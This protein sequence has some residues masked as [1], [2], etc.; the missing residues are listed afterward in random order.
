MG[1]IFI[2]INNYLAKRKGLVF[3]LLIVFVALVVYSVIRLKKNE[4]FTALF[5]KD[6][7]FEKFDLIIKK[8]SFADKIV[9]YFSLKDTANK[10]KTELLIAK[11]DPFVDSV[12]KNFGSQIKDIKYTV[13]DENITKL[14]SFFYNNLPIFLTKA[15]YKL[16]AERIADSNVASTLQ[17]D[18]NLLISPA[19]I[20][21]KQFILKDPFGMIPLAIGKLNQFQLGENFTIADNR[22]F[23]KDKNDLFVFL[24]VSNSSDTHKLKLLLAGLEK[25][26][27]TEANSTVTVNYFG[28][29]VVAA[30]NAERIKKDIILTVCITLI[31]IFLLL[32]LYFKNYFIPFL[33]FIPVIVGGGIS[34]IVIYLIKGEISAISMGVGSVLLGIGIDYSIHFFTH[35]KQTQSVSELLKDISAP[36]LMSS[37]T[38][39][40]AFLCLFIIKS[41]V[42]QDLGIFA[43]VSVLSTAFAALII[44]P[45]IFR[46]LKNTKSG[47]RQMLFPDKIAFIRFEDNKYL[48]I[49]ILLLT[50]VFYFTGKKTSFNEN[51][52]DMNYMPDDLKKAE[53]FLNKKTAFATSSFYLVA[54]GK[55]F[56]E[57]LNNSEKLTSQLD[58]LK[59]EGAIKEFFSVNSILMTPAV[60]SEK[61]EQWNAFWE[62]KRD[63]L[64]ASIKENGSALGFKTNAFNDFYQLLNRDYEPLPLSGFN[65]IQKLYLSDYL[66]FDPDM[67]AVITLIKADHA[68]KKIIEK[69]INESDNI[70]V[71]DRQNVTESLLTVIKSEFHFLILLS[72]AMVFL[73]LILFFG[74]IELAVISFIP[75]VL[76]WIWTIGI[77]GLFNIH[78]NIFNVIISTFIFGLGVDY[79]I[80][81]TNGLLDKLQFGKDNI[82]T[83]KTSILLAGITT[84]FGTGVLIFAQH[85]ALKSIAMVSVIG[86]S[87][88]ILISFTVQPMLFNFLAYYKGKK[89]ALP[90][91]MFNFIFSITSL[92]YFVVSS[93]TIATLVIPL[94]KLLPVKSRSRKSFIHKAIWFFSWTVV[95]HN[96]H[97]RKI[98]VSIDK[99]TFKK[100]VLA[101]SNHQSVLDL[102]FL[103]MLHPKINIVAN[104]RALYN[105]FY[106]PAIRFTDFIYADEGMDELVKVIKKRMDEGYSVII[107]PEGTRSADSK[108]KRFH[109]GAFYIAEKLNLKLL[110]LMLHGS[111]EA[112]NKKEFFLRRGIVHIKAFH[113][114]DTTSDQ[115]GTTYQEKAKAMRKFYIEELEKLNT[116]IWVPDRMKY[117]LINRFIYRGPV[118]EWYLRIKLHLE[119]NY[120]LI[121]NRVPRNASILD[122]GCGYGF[123]ATMLALITDTRKVTGVDYDSHKITTAKY[124]T[125]DLEN[126]EF[127]CADILEWDFPPADVIILSDVLHYM[128]KEKQKTLLEKCIHIVSEKG[129]VIVRDADADLKK[130]T[131]GTKITEFFST[132]FGFNKTKE[133]LDFSSGT[134]IVDT[135]K[136]FGLK[137]ERIDDTKYTSN[138][139]YILSK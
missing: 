139:T 44:L 59:N 39:V 122:L 121:N 119:N 83:F 42:F 124:C 109:K 77:M 92:V 100:P 110:P 108:I 127:I 43:S 9:I 71:F 133:K 64:I 118:L 94:I 116:E 54:S 82:F 62:N 18:L 47:Q 132:R 28:A 86:I 89:R 103:L 4:D 1:Q 55:S 112:L 27:H 96:V 136:D 14:Y 79:S 97:V 104:Q 67:S 123:L 129:M 138:I 13:S 111:G 72:S 38:T 41:D 30:A 6:T 11:A 40:S 115:W 52:M 131:T 22:I 45:L 29:P 105:P 33:L 25:Y 107:F 58:S 5:P 101:I 120:N 15:D 17:K 102:V 130:R 98:L 95:Y 53:D 61:I 60:Q 46:L 113:E 88:A 20:A 31:F 126:L 66:I 12:E 21:M 99:N 128:S 32:G 3:S 90:V 84:L 49:A 50:I 36:I 87:S 91:T 93:L 63:N 114:I 80:F 70:V 106:G 117:N 7:R 8:S 34:I 16:I 78:F 65:L 48:I 2:F 69:S 76:S 37:I 74:R 85:P 125:E 75:I 19:G 26:A 24:T 56:E 137:T 68:H 73:I 23:S 10:R 135:A 51:L 134:L 81:I 57:A 35:L